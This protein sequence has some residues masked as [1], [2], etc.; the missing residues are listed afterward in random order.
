[1]KAKRVGA[2]EGETHIPHTSRRRSPEVM[3]AAPAL[4]TRN[5]QRALLAAPI[6]ARHRKAPHALS[7]PVTPEV[8][9]SNPVASVKT[10]K[11]ELFC[12]RRPQTIAGLF[13]GPVLILRLGGDDNPNLKVTMRLLALPFETTKTCVL[14]V[15]RKRMMGLEPTTFCMASRRSSQLS[16]IRVGRQYS[17]GRGLPGT[18]S[19][20][21]R[22][23]RSR[24]GPRACSAPGAPPCIAPPR[25]RGPVSRPGRRARATPRS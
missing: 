10:C 24:A 17:R 12:P 8:A 20:L 13:V 23:L 11:S 2:G 18:L 22:A 1:M 19:R 7:R 4:P 9:G 6:R 5:E 16:Y 14:Q 3:P 25:S 21:R 15:L